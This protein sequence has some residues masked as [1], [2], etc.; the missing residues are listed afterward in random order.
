[1]LV[2]IVK[3]AM[4]SYYRKNSYKIIISF[5]YITNRHF[6]LY[7]LGHE[8]EDTDDFTWSPYMDKALLAA[9]ISLV[10]VN[11][12]DQCLTDYQSIQQLFDVLCPNCNPGYDVIKTRTE[13]FF[14]AAQII[15]RMINPGF[16][17]AADGLL[18]VGIDTWDDWFEVSTAF[19][20]S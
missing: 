19:Q 20:C 10:R 15:P 18:V 14:E 8:Y 7:L 11:I 5:I 13:N 16:S 9:M 4:E 2:F 1:M 12:N 17:I 3:I 6:L